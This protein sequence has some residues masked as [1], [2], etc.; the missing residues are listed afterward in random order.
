MN[1]R[2]WMSWCTSRSVYLLELLPL[3]SMSSLV[4]LT[5]IAFL[6]VLDGF[7]VT[8]SFLGFFFFMA[9][10]FVASSYLSS[11]IMSTRSML[12][13]IGA[14]CKTCT[15]G[16]FEDKNGMA[17]G[18]ASQNEVGAGNIWGQCHGTFDWNNRA[19]LFNI[20]SISSSFISCEPWDICVKVISFR[21]WDIGM[22]ELSLPCWSFE[23]CKSRMEFLCS[24]VWAC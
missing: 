20:L 1:S 4:R 7:L 17:N 18:L 8:T 12:G 2:K 11:W 9:L 19:L 16:P 14:I 22:K 10:P 3:L 6:L 24:P 21:P 13:P 15:T 5:T 23:G